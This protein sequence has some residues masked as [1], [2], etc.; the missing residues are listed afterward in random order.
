MAAPPG[1]PASAG[2]SGAPVVPSG[3]RL[4]GRALVA[5]ERFR[6]RRTTGARVATVLS[7]LS[8][9]PAFGDWTHKIIHFF[10][11]YFVPDTAS[12]LESSVYAIIAIAI[13]V[14]AAL[15]LGDGNLQFSLY[16]VALAG[17]V[18]FLLRLLAA[19]AFLYLVSLAY[20]SDV[21]GHD[22]ASIFFLLFLGL[23]AVVAVAASWRDAY[24]RPRSSFR[25]SSVTPVGWPNSTNWSMK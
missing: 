16:L 12:G 14:G 15:V 24:C 7:L 1:Y 9:F 19:W 8:A 13:A 22:P 2:R 10:F 4:R 21:V 20:V 3:P 5:L 23:L 17:M 6:L 11:L 25:R 18:F